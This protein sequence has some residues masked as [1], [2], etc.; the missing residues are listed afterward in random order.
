[1]MAGMTPKTQEASK[2]ADKAAGE[3]VKQAKPAA[4][5]AKKTK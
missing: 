3:P 4:K 2:A 1:M 5:Q